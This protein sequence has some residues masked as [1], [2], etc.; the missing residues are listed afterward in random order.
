MT[1]ILQIAVFS[2]YSYVWSI[3]KNRKKNNIFCYLMALNGHV[4]IWL[5]LPRAPCPKSFFC[6]PD[7]FSLIIKTRVWP[8]EILSL[9]VFLAENTV[10]FS[11]CVRVCDARSQRLNSHTYIHTPTQAKAAGCF[12][13]SALWRCVLSQLWGLS[14]FPPPHSDG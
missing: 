3:G 10:F 9:S 13:L 4:S 14:S 5:F 7:L 8:R 2:M 1:T 11:A 12:L 6:W